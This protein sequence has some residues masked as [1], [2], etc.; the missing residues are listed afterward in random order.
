MEGA[1]STVLDRSSGTWMFGRLGIG[2]RRGSVSRY[3]A[4]VTVART[5]PLPKQWLTSLLRTVHWRVG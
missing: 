2:L 5:F 3:P 4:L 1:G